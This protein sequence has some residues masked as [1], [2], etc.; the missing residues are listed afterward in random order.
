MRRRA[1][2]H[3]ELRDVACGYRPILAGA[4]GLCNLTPNDAIGDG[5]DTNAD[6]TFLSTFP[7]AAPPNQ[8]YE[9][10]GHE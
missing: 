2:P 1:V 10:T 6:A 8:G 4:V 3:G 5:V 7:Y 9:H